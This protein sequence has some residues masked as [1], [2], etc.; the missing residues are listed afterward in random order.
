MRFAPLLAALLVATYACS[1]VALRAANENVDPAAAPKAA[2]AAN[3][4]APWK[5]VN[6][7]LAT[8]PGVERGVLIQGRGNAWRNLRPLI[9]LGG[10]VLLACSVAALGLFYLWR[11]P[12]GVSAPLTGRLIERFSVAD[13]LAHWS[14]GISFVVLGISGLLLAAGRRLLLPVIGYEVFSPIALACK[15]LH[16][17]LGPLFMLSLAYFIARYFR[18]NLPR[19]HDIDWLRQLGGMFS[20]KHVPSG[21]FNAGEKTLFWGLVCAFSAILCASGLIM[22]FPN[23]EQGRALM[24]DATIIH[25]AIAFLAIAASLFHMY[26]GTVGVEGAY[27]GMR[28]GVVDESWAREHHEIWYDEV[29]AGK[30][31]QHY[32]GPVAPL[33][34]APSGDD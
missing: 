11:G 22:D 8:I 17:F 25:L 28:D 14:M 2:Q 9:V 1:P 19:R 6:S 27:R 20:R 26:L 12:I 32:V 33:A 31:R 18:D 30:S 7:G 4:V 5:G 34:V 10:G 24:Q 23:F 16:A 29:K 3:D 21:R 13:R 15:N